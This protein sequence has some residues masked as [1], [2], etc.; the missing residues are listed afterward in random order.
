L[1]LSYTANPAI[2]PEKSFKYDVGFDASLLKGLDISFD[3]FKD[4]RSGIIT[5]NN[6]I[7]AVFGGILPFVNLG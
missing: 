1:I 2:S 5:Q 7:M 4:S 3:L 6:S